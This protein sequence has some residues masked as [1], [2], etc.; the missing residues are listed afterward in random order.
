MLRLSWRAII[1]GAADGL[2][3]AAAPAFALM[4]LLTAMQSGDAHGMRCMGMP[5]ASPWSSMSLMYVLMSVF[6]AAPWIRRR[7]HQKS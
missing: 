1:R 2:H 3:L 6:H 7:R 5:D 4:A